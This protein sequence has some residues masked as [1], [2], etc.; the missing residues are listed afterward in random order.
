MTDLHIISKKGKITKTDEHLLFRDIEGNETRIL[1]SKIKQ[2]L[3]GSFPNRELK[4]I[5][6]RAS[7][8]KLKKHKKSEI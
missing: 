1:P 7:Y 8:L 5:Y 2:I 3:L 4:A 6:N